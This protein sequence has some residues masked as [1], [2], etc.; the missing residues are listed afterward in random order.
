MKTLKSFCITALSIMLLFAC[1]EQEFVKSDKI[2]LQDDISVQYG[3]IDQKLEL[4][5]KAHFYTRRNYSEEGEGFCTEDPFFAYNYQVGEGEATHL[6]RFTT[7]MQFCGAGFDYTNGDGVFIAAN[8]DKLFIKIPSE[9]VIGHILPY[10]HHFYELQFQDAF[11][12]NGGTGRFENA[13][14]WGMTNSFVDLFD[15]ENNFIPEHQ[16]DHE[17]IGTLILPVKKN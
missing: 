1:E 16:T 2:T 14:G 3:N 17:W 10:D 4:P 5:F 12:F 13:S 7:T 9:G 6:G 8:G 11:S 15:D